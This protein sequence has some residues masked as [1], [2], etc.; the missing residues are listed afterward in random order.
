M[1]FAI[2]TL[3]DTRPTELIASYFVHGQGNDLQRS[4]LGVCRALLNSILEHYPEFL[5]QLTKDFENRNERYGDYNEGRWHWSVGELLHLLSRVLTVGTKRQPITIF[6]D[7]LDECG[8]E[9]AR[10]LLNFFYEQTHSE[11]TRARICVSSRHYP[12]LG[13]DSIPALAMEENNASDIIWYTQDRLKS[14]QCSHKRREIEA[15]ILDKAHGAFQWVYLATE[16]V[17]TGD[18]NGSKLDKLQLDLASCPGTLTERYA[19]ILNR[20]GGSELR[21]MVKLFE[22]ILFSG[23]PLS[24]QELR[25]ALTT[26]PDVECASVLKLRTHSSYS[27][28]LSSFERHVKHL[29]RGLVVFQTREVWEIYDLKGEDWN[30]E[31]QLIHQS[32]ADFL[33][34]NFLKRY[35][36]GDRRVHSSLAGGGHYRISRS[37]LRYLTMDEPLNGAHL[38]RATLASRFPLAPYAVRYIFE[39]IRSAE[40]EGILQHDLLRVMEWAPKSERLPKLSRLWTTLDPGGAHTPIGWPFF[41]ATALHVVAALGSKS[42]ASQLDISTED[43]ARTDSDG[44]TALMIA[45]R[46]GN[47]DLAEMLIRLASRQKTRPHITS[48]SDGLQRVQGLTSSSE[49]ASR[50]LNTSNEDGDTALAIALDEQAI[51]VIIDLFEADPELDTKGQES[52]LVACAIAT[53]DSRLLKILFVRHIN[54]EG[55]VFFALFEKSKESEE[56]LLNLVSTL[57]QAGA[58]TRRSQSLNW[59]STQLQTGSTRID[60]RD[61][62]LF[63]DDALIIAT[64]RGYLSLVD[65]LISHGASVMTPNALG[66]TSLAV[67]VRKGRLDIVQTLLRH[68][69]AATVTNPKMTRQVL[70]AALHSGDPDIFHHLLQHRHV[71]DASQTPERLV[72][73]ISRRGK[74]GLMRVL[75]EKHNINPNLRDEKGRSSL[76]FAA[77]NGHVEL[78]R[79]LLAKSSVD[80]NSVDHNQDSPLHKAAENGHAAAVK[81]LLDSGADPELIQKDHWTALTSAVH[82]GRL[83]VVKELIEHGVD[84]NAPGGDYSTALGAAAYHGHQDLVELL[85][86]AGAEIDM[87]IKVYGTAFGAALFEGNQDTAELLLDRGA[88]IHKEGGD[89]N[90]ALGVAAFVG[91]KEMTALLLERGANIHVQGKY[92]ASTLAAAAY[93]GNEDI[94]LRL[95]EEGANVHREGGQYGSAL[96]AAAYAGNPQIVQMLLEHGADLDVTSEAG[97]TP[98]HYAS[99]NG[100]FEA[101]ALLLKYNAAVDIRNATGGTALIS[102]TEKECLDIVELLL[103]HGAGWSFADDY[104]WTA[105]ITAAH[106]GNTKLVRLLLERGADMT[107]DNRGWTPLRAAI[108]KGHINA[109]K[110]LLDAR[111]PMTADFDY[112][113]PLDVA[114]GR[115]CIQIVEL[116]LDHGAV[117]TPNTRGWTALHL[118]CRGG[119]VEI[120]RMLQKKGAEFLPTNTGWTPLHFAAEGGAEE[121]ASLLLAAGLD[122][123]AADSEEQTPLMAASRRA[124]ASMVSWL[125]EMGANV[126]TRTKRGTTALHVAAQE[127]HLA[128]VQLL[129]EKGADIFATEG[130]K[131]PLCSATSNGNLEVARYLLD[132]GSDLT[133]ATPDKWR[134]LNFAVENH[135]LEIVQLFLDRGAYTAA[136]GRDL[137]HVTIAHLFAFFGLTDFLRLIVDRYRADL[138]Q[139][140][141]HDRTPLELAARS[142]NPATFHY[143]VDQ[144]LKPSSGNADI[145][146]LAASGGSIR[147]MTDLME[148]DPAM[149]ARL[150]SKKGTWNLLHWACRSG[151]LELVELLVNRGFKSECIPCPESEDNWTPLAV[152]VFHG[153]GKLVDEMPDTLKLELDLGRSGP[154]SDGPT[155]G[156]ICDGCLHV[157]MLEQ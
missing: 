3:R 71:L 46:E 128:I 108:E 125:I 77:A 23:R 111:A 130:G 6:I 94:A 107:V 121:I 102:A 2:L 114:S 101:V 105:L 129:C 157:S 68:T 40:E 50:V 47:H 28:T 33:L 147:I 140:D 36:E 43:L 41:A 92:F 13:L 17:I 57:L 91:N 79:A 82:R 59:T 120:F 96:G 53:M 119:H 155:H 16:A 100:H 52:G 134:P 103:D 12:I 38:S 62:L 93:G 22:W 10:S 153:K 60:E 85:L 83:K 8:E 144:G 27:D 20:V 86:D 127:G 66:E 37:C 7:A 30:R 78:A 56:A 51:D 75:L 45:I 44:N 104:G 115:G 61:E 63:D 131:T 25:E 137:R 113:T 58:D 152:A 69:P 139:T 154:L 5:C 116:L 145:Y 97:D 31:A 15:E 143:L 64:R 98:L 95:T 126:S 42:A 70:E 32:V 99:V 87:S 148:R 150:I 54:L 67:A 146:N 156:A 1:K 132:V 21:Q 74:V 14:I 124:Q 72:S 18:L 4:T 151:L 26:E 88:D 90:N 106:T 49:A 141:A 135:H 48:H 123:D 89:Y 9:T 84:V 76:W 34:G 133:H 138:T 11:A 149:N 136:D 80:I 112:W 117:P 118:A 39:H 65:L 73:E 81:L 142:G 55:A 29:S 19:A 24:A 110:V 35:Y 122:V 109:T